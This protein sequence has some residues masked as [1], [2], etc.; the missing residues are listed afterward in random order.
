M[1]TQ[2]RNAALLAF[3]YFLWGVF[4]IYWSSLASVPPIVVVALRILLSAGTII[5]ASMFFKGISLR[6]SA[7]VRAHLPQLVCST[8]FI[9]GNWAIYIW[10]VSKGYVFECGTG[11][12]IC[13][14]LFVAYGVI[15]GEERMSNSTLVALTIA[16]G[17]VLY[18]IITYGAIPWLSFGL[19][20]TFVVYGVIH[21]RISLNVIEALFIESIIAA[22]LALLI[23]MFTDFDTSILTRSE[24]FLMTQIGIVTLVP[25]AIFAKTVRQTNMLTV[26]M[27]QNIN[28]VCQVSLG[29]WWFNETIL[30]ETKLTAL[31]AFTALSVYI[32]AA[33]RQKYL[34][35]K[36]IR[37]SF[38]FNKEDATLFS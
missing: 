34:T 32:G 19:A 6:F 37:S 33:V 14:L 23:L 5:I 24:Y 36:V 2:S 38:C 1:T 26:G 20:I 29:I 30:P 25:V 10:G 4:P 7:N 17:G 31:S 28:P 13:P 12:F 16:V 15:R 3:S 18:S 9:V 22:P 21:R 11:Y 27:L 8:L 35:N